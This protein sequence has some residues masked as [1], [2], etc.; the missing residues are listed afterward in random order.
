[1][2]TVGTMFIFVLPASASSYGGSNSYLGQLLITIGISI[3][4]LLLL[5]EVNCWYWK[6]NERNSL[7]RDIK[8][9]LE[10]SSRNIP[11]NPNNTTKKTNKCLRISSVTEGGQAEQIGIKVGDI[12]TKY[13][14][15]TITTDAELSKAVSLAK[16]QKKTTVKIEFV[17]GDVKEIV[18]ATVAPLGIHCTDEN[19][20]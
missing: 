15:T 5:R 1:M 10:E 13:E 3:A 17:R 20:D 7:L 14:D 4:V 19:F 6:I 11:Q 12:L 16:Y 9:L 2:F 18:T 8:A